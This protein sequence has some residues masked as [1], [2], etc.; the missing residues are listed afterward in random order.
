LA[1]L[2]DVEEAAL[3]VTISAAHPPFPRHARPVFL[4][5][6]VA[7]AL[8][9]ASVLADVP[10]AVPLTPG[11]LLVSRSVYAGD[12]STVTIGQFLPGGGTKKAVADGSYPGVWANESPDP[13]FGITSPIFIDELTP[14]G[15][16]VQTLPVPTTGANQMVTSFPSKS[17]LALNLSPDGTLI[18]FMGYVSAPNT[19]DVSNSNT[20]G[21]FDPTNPVA[22]TFQ[23]AVGQLDLGGNLSV[24][25]VNTYSGNNGRAA[26]AANGAFFMVGNAGNGSGTEPLVVINNT[27]VQMTVGSPDTIAVGAQKGTCS[28]TPAANG[29][30]FGFSITDIGL[31]ADKSGKDDN[32]RG[33]TIFGN[34]L[35]VTKGSGSNGVN[36]VYQVGASGVL[37]T[38]ATAATTPVTILPGFPTVLAR[39]TTAP[40]PRFPFGL[41]FADANTVYVTDEGDGT[42]VNAAT[43]TKA[44]L[45]KWIFAGGTWQLAYTLQDGL[46]LGVPYAIANGPHGEVYP[47]SLDPATDGLRN[48]AGVVNGDGTVTIYAVTSTVSTNTDQ[49]ADPNRL[50]TVTDVV[51]ANTA[52]QV[53]GEHFTTIRTAGY[54]EVLRGVSVAGPAA[55]TR[56]GIVRD[57]RTGTYAQQLTVRNTSSN[58]IAGPILVVLDNLSANASLANPTGT[59]SANP[60]VGGPYISIPGTSLGLAPGATASVVLQFANPTSGAIAY[61][62]RVLPGN[63]IP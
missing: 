27:G 13:S 15:S 7:L 33:L 59:V 9:G 36:T 60:P 51:S 10:T 38:V 11:D 22:S 50:V 25:P 16:L 28:P 46:N 63:R 32:F 58:T 31:A 43:D 4:F 47:P 29:C 35:Y 53:V 42:T 40:L 20:P 21:H 12:A 3:R 37:P 45:Q 2:S 44:G 26:I 55:V 41:W 30:Q 1:I 5:G 49:G 56:S 61:T 23:R 54:G 17:E 57:R 24:T 6:A 62:T 18:T 48:I 19:L 14:T 34:T 8:V 39:S 52:S